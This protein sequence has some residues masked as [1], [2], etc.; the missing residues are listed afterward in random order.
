MKITLDTNVL[1][2][3]TFWYGSS[4]KIVE[5]VENNKID[6]ILSKEIL[7]E[8]T[9]VLDYKEIQDKIK[10]KNL[11]MKYSI[12]KIISLSTIVKPRIK[13]NIIKDDKADN[14][15]LECAKEGKVNYIISQDKHLLKLGKFENIDI[16]KPD[17]F[18][19]KIKE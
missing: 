8:Y 18:L 15:I 2:S 11:E 4:N 6:I 16:L 12:Q 19:R 9:E 1:I 3:A 14:R 10:N 17:E 5:L 13:I 7:K